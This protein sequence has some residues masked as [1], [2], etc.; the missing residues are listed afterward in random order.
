MTLQLTF[1]SS[2]EVNK[3]K[4]QRTLIYLRYLL[5]GMSSIGQWDIF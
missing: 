3:S 4:Y 2:F 1:T 5:V